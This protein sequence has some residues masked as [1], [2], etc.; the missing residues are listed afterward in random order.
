MADILVR[1]L[2]KSFVSRLKRAAREH[3]RSLQSEVKAILA[4]NAP[5]SMKQA[6]AVSKKW[7]KHFAGRRLSD[8]TKD[9]RE[10]RDSR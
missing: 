9:I 3:G 10:D 7:Q 8:S 2:E 5:Y 6:L 1:G 4:E